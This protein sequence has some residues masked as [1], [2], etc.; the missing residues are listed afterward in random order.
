MLTP[1]QA[2]NRTL[3]A[4]GRPVPGDEERGAPAPI[5]FTDFKRLMWKNY[6]HTPYHAL[7]DEKLEQLALYILSGGQQG[8]RNLMLNLPP[9][10]GKSETSHKFMAW[11]IGRNPD[12][13]IIGSSYG[14]NL[15]TRNSRAVRR[16]I[17]DPRFQEI[18]PNV[19]LSDESS[20]VNRWNIQGHD[21]GMIA[22]GVGAGVAGWGSYLNVVDDIVRSRA[23]AESPTYQENTI[24]WWQNDMLTRLEEPGGANL[25]I[26]TRYHMNDLAGYLLENEPEDWEVVKLPALAGEDDPLGREPGEALWPERYSKE[27]LEKRK[28]KVGLYAF[29]ALYQQEPKPREGTL[30]DTAK[31]DIIDYEPECKRIVRF[32]DLAVTKKTTA[33]YTAGLKL[34]VT[35]KEEFIVFDVYRAQKTAPEIQEAIVQNAAL[36]GRSVNIRLE[37]EK[38]G[39][40]Q[41]DY[42]LND[43]RMRPYSIDKKAP[44]GSKY[45]RATAPAA[46][47]NA[48][49]VKLVKGRW[50][51]AFLDELAMFDQGENDDQVDAFSGAYDML[52]GGMAPED[53]FRQGSIRSRTN[54]D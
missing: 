39:I 6:V 48:G 38:A 20:A 11:L 27:W 50:N 21:G 10:H 45:T 25:F 14:A 43:S 18:F 7:M 13:P 36:D 35:Q 8:I 32:Y 54:D 30:F 49:K 15:A 26:G 3:R 44:E 47:V 19:R 4:M 31:I 22:V 23:V 1:Q 42:L 24:D 41:L 53:L 16:I 9:R 51:K 34:G 29:S 17:L 28:A 40:I 37:A 5:S 12:I 46:R 2:V 52:S 33:D